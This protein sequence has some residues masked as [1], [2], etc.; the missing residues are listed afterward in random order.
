MSF[1]QF[2]HNGVEVL[3]DHVVHENSIEGGDAE[4]EQSRVP[5]N[6]RKRR[7]KGGGHGRRKKKN[8]RNNAE[9][10][11]MIPIRTVTN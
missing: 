11:S 5:K 10:I 4:T 9:T 1:Q 8:H 7:L 2:A 3:F 6:Q